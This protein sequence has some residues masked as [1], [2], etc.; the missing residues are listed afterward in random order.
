M[1]LIV[2]CSG[3]L[4]PWVRKMPTF[5]WLQL[6]RHFITCQSE[7]QRNTV[8]FFSLHSVSVLAFLLLIFSF[9]PISSSPS[10]AFSL[11]PDFHFLCSHF[12]R[13]FFFHQLR[14]LMLSHHFPSLCLSTQSFLNLYRYSLVVPLF[15]ELYLVDVTFWRTRKI[16]LP[17]LGCASS[18]CSFSHF[19]SCCVK[20]GT[21]DCT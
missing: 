15:E 13:F 7:H 4:K 3:I 14:F 16:T 8:V 21:W 1:L 2:L 19:V 5:W 11:P 12:L 10:H 6:T 18:Q 17:A 20:G 9:I